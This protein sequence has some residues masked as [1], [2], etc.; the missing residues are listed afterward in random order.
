MNEEL[1]LVEIVK[2]YFPKLN[3]N[4]ITKAYDFGKK[5]HKNQLRASGD[6]FFSHPFEVANILAHMKLDEDSIIT[7]LLHDVIEDTL[8]TK[9][10]IKKT[11]GNEIANLVDGV[12]KLSKLSLNQTN[13]NK[14]I[15]NLRKFILAISEDIRVLFVKFADRLHNMRTINFLKDIEKRKRIANETL[16]IFAPLADRIGIRKI[17]NE[18]NDLAFEELNPSVR[19]TIIKRINFL[20]SEG[21]S[22]IKIII[23]QLQRILKKSN[24][25]SE[26]IGREKTPYSIWR[27]IK[28][29][30]Y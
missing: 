29:K 2:N 15:E 11:F 10:E 14:Q 7:G 1:K 3:V 12:T 27:K 25:K 23:Q 21:K 4:N 5:A 26:I 9:E 19:S 8:A 28:K 22:N 30:K 17:K 13:K 16:D 24:I 18:L 20:K 6:P